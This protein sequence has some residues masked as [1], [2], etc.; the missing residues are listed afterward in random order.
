MSHVNN[1]AV[2]ISHFKLDL[3]LKRASTSSGVL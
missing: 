1:Y 3:I 2:Y